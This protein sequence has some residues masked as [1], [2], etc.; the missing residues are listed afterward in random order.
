MYK[1]TR[2][3]FLR[4]YISTG[5]L[6]MVADKSAIQKLMKDRELI[7]ENAIETVLSKLPGKVLNMSPHSDT[8]F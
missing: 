4:K 6:E 8:L 3:K 1:F 5:L 2:K 7:T